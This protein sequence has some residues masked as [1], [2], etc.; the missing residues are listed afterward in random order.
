[1]PDLAALKAIPTIPPPAPPAEAPSPRPATPA[2]KPPSTAKGVATPDAVS[3]PLSE[4]EFTALYLDPQFSM[5]LSD[6]EFDTL[7]EIRVGQLQGAAGLPPMLLAQLRAGGMGQAP[8]AEFN[9]LLGAGPFADIPVDMVTPDVFAFQALPFDSPL[10]EFP[11]ELSDEHLPETP[12]IRDMLL[13]SRLTPTELDILDRMRADIV[14]APPPVPAPPPTVPEAPTE[15]PS[16]GPSA[17]V[18]PP[19]TPPVIPP[20]VPPPQPPSGPPSRPPTPPRPPP[21]P[22]PG[23]GPG[24]GPG[25]PPEESASKL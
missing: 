11:L 2:G 7:I 5:L 20:A 19:P 17:P 4:T 10:A 23:P 14:G 16:V 3:P 22:P 25:P 13:D 12:P 15:V 9:L 21:G 24:P 6:P 8:E 18:T 1:M